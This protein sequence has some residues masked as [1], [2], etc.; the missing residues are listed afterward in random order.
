M[1]RGG[2]GGDLPPPPLRERTLHGDQVRRRRHREVGGLQG[3]LQRAG[4]RIDSAELGWLTLAL[5]LQKETGGS[6]AEVMQTRSGVRPNVD[7]ALA[8]L[9]LEHGMP[10]DAGETIFAIAR[11]AGWI[12]HALE[13]YADRPSRFR[14]SGEYAGRTPTG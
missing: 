3:R 2:G 13:E 12:A 6:L 9:T 7:L 4:E 1:I 11:T 5:R 8:A 10:A 14:P